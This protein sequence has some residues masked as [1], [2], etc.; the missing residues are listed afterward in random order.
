MLKSL[1]ELL[2]QRIQ[3][4]V[5]V[6]D[7]PGADLFTQFVGF[8]RGKITERNRD[9][10]GLFLE[11]RNTERALEDRSQAL[12]GISHRLESLAPSQ[13]RMNHVTLDRTG[14]DDRDL[15]DEIVKTGRLEARQH[16]HLCA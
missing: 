9:A 8:A 7:A 11:D 4:A 10:H 3:V 2:Q 16:R 15:D 5:E 14:A 13:I 1:F 12:V 6:L